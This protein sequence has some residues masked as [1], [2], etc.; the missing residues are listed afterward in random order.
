MDA[1]YE[2]SGDKETV[3][4][5]QMRE[6]AIMDEQSRLKGARQEGIKEGENNKAIEI[7]KKL[8]GI[9]PDEI[10]SIKTGISVDIIKELKNQ[11]KLDSS[12][13]WLSLRGILYI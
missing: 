3:L 5:A 12:E 6:K 2:V 11:V 1:L 10:I 9:I 7:A 13:I 4:L 8:I